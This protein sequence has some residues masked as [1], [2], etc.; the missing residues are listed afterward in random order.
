VMD[1]NTY[2]EVTSII[3]TTHKG[4]LLIKIRFSH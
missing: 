1:E 3:L 4:K 2:V